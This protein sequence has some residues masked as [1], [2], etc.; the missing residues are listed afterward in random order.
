[1]AT[2]YATF[3]AITIPR[4]FKPKATKKSDPLTVAI[5]KLFA[6]NAQL[7]ASRNDKVWSTTLQFSS[8]GEALRIVGEF[9]RRLVALNQNVP[10]HIGVSTGEI[11]HEQPN[12]TDLPY[13]RAQW[14]ADVA[15]QNCILIS[16][17]TN[18]IAEDLELFPY[19]AICLGELHNVQMG[20][21]ETVWA[22]R[23]FELPEPE[24]FRDDLTARHNIPLSDTFVIGRSDEIEQIQ[25]QLQRDRWVTLLGPSGV[26]KSVLAHRVARELCIELDEEE[27][28]PLMRDGVRFVDLAGAT[29]RDEVV[30]RMFAAIGMQVEHL[31]AISDA[32]IRKYFGNRRHLILFDGCERAVPD[33]SQIIKS[34]L[35][36]SGVYVLATSTTP[37]EPSNNHS[38]RIQ[39]LG[40]PPT[41]KSL[42]LEDLETY[43]ATA[44]MLD[45]MRLIHHGYHPNPD[46]IKLIV[47]ICRSLAGHP[48]AISLAAKRTRSESLQEVLALVQGKKQDAHLEREGRHDSLSASVRW[49][50]DSLPPATC[51]V[52]EWASVFEDIW[53]PD[54]LAELIGEDVKT[55]RAPI[56]FLEDLGLI[57]ESNLLEERA[58]Y[59]LESHIRT[60]IR[61]SLEREKDWRDI[62]EQHFMYFYAKFAALMPLTGAN[63]AENLAKLDAM[64]ADFESALR[65]LIE[66]RKSPR[67]FLEVSRQCWSYWYRRN[68]LRSGIS[69]ADECLAICGPEDKEELVSMDI[70]ASIFLTKAGDTEQA[71][72]RLKRAYET[73]KDMNDLVLRA[74]VLVNLSSAYW[75]NANPELSLECGQE[76]LALGREANHVPM[77]HSALSNVAGAALNL[78]LHELYVDCLQE[79]E[80]I[81]AST[82]DHR[83]KWGI[84]IGWAEILCE[85]GKY[86]EAL[87]RIE[88]SLAHAE[89]SG[90]P[91][92]VGRSYLWRSQIMLELGRFEESA[93]NLGRCLYRLSSG[94][95]APFKV[96]EIRIARIEGRLRNAIG[97]ANLNFYKLIGSG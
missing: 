60:A 87:E 53:M 58:G 5:E 22:L 52:L 41:S 73:V 44:L 79:Y 56:E 91:T 2:H 51:S 82:S 85:T 66:V 30:G 76:A 6:A 24:P 70:L 42:S 92:I 93:E 90:D 37:L 10:F 47:E 83:T 96:N 31:G 28:T 38:F 11:A 33:V 1:M 81:G 32:M 57:V 19:W 80:Q 59:R 94:D 68:R 25:V 17:I 13:Q 97:D 15:P 27:G 89:R 45:R 63:Q 18:A 84:D 14:L 77:I 95:Q 26:G 12:L 67:D 43:E 49:T 86:D 55:I 40:I 29:T 34:L 74:R 64:R 35:S 50:I 20:R 75:A 3:V 36:T 7:L 9:A 23:H 39:P 72:S 65:F 69:L 16:S 4:P 61:D 48:L 78:G 46:E 54:D 21:T 71:I 88:L 62:R 8:V